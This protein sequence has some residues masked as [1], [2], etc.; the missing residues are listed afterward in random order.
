MFTVASARLGYVKA[1]AALGHALYFGHGI[2]KNCPSSRVYLIS[3]AKKCKRTILLVTY[4]CFIGLK[5]MS[6]KDALSVRKPDRLSTKTAASNNA[7]SQQEAL[8]YYEYSAKSGDGTASILLAQLYYF[9]TEGSEP[10][11]EKARL[12]FENS[13]AFGHESSYAFLGQIYYRGEGVP[14][15]YQKAFEYFSKAAERNIA[16]ALN[17]LGLIYW[18][19]QV[20]EKDLDMAESYFKQAAD[21]KY[22]EAFYNYAL[23]LLEQPALFNTEKV[24]QN[25]LAATK[26]GKF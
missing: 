25:F 7:K 16:S 13:I 3:A 11:Y 14:V 2:E 22:P 18:H 21:L 6:S 17:G 19:G 9:G 26:L 23:V 12:N 8:E 10:N 20:V 15:D 1:H 24:F 5:E 4:I